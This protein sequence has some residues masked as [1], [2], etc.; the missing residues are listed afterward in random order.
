MNPNPTYAPALFLP[1]LTTNGVIAVHGATKDEALNFI[2]HF[3]SDVEAARKVADAPN[4]TTEPFE[5]IDGNL[6]LE[7]LV[8]G[9]SM[10]DLVESLALSNVRGARGRRAVFVDIENDTIG[11]GTTVIYN[12]NR[13][14]RGVSDGTVAGTVFQAVTAQAQAD[15]A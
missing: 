10:S 1:S 2:K 15:A 13:A 5:F 12:E 4:A 6:G 8:D 7:A 9:E 14:M 3:N 11:V